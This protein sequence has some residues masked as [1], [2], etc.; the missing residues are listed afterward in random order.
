MPHTGRTEDA[1][2]AMPYTHRVGRKPPCER[3][4]TIGA[5]AAVSTAAASLVHQ[6]HSAR[7]AAHLPSL[8]RIVCPDSARRTQAR[9]LTS[10]RVVWL[11]LYS[12][13]AITR[14]RRTASRS[15]APAPANRCVVPRCATPPRCGRCGSQCVVRPSTFFIA[16]AWLRG[17]A[18]PASLIHH[19]HSMLRGPQYVP[20]QRLPDLRGGWWGRRLHPRRC[21]CARCLGGAHRPTSSHT[22]RDDSDSMPRRSAELTQ[23]ADALMSVNVT[24]QERSP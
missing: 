6:V 8:R 22:L 12:H 3:H 15:C 23:I 24:S 1:R 7:H 19:R 20:F 18:L 13:R 4:V 11:A 10:H 21:A 17:C 14:M 9:M 16:C 2:T 5:P